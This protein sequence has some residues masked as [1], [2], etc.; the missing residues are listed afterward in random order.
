MDASVDRHDR[1]WTRPPNQITSMTVSG[2]TSMVRFL[3]PVMVC[4][5]ITRFSHLDGASFFV[6][7]KDR[8]PWRSPVIAE[9]PQKL[10]C[11]FG[12][13]CRVRRT[14][15]RLPRESTCIFLKSGETK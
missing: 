8:R 6:P 14:W 5:G 1:P 4:G 11:S 10:G 15:G 2:G 9:L 13:A 7:F 12:Q 3:L